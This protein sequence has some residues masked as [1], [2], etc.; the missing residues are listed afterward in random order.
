VSAIAGIVALDAT[1]LDPRIVR[2]FGD[3]VASCA[4]R[5][6]GRSGTEWVGRR[7]ALF[8]RALRP[9]RRI[10]GAPS[11][12]ATQPLKRN[13]CVLVFDGRVDNSEEM[14]AALDVRSPLADEALVLAAYERWGEDCFAKLLGDFALAIWDERRG[15]LVCARD[16]FG[17]RPLQ[18]RTEGG[19]LAFA[20]E[21][22]PLLSL[23]EAMPRP[24]EC[25]AAEYLAFT[26]QSMHET[27]FD[28]VYRLPPAHALVATRGQTR[29]F[30]YWEPRTTRLHYADEADYEAHFNEVFREAVRCRLRADGPV[31]IAL[32]GG[33]D[34]SSVAVVASSLSLSSG[35]E[36]P[37]AV[38]LIYPGLAC[39]ES[40]YI[41][42]VVG[43]AAMKSVRTVSTI[44]QQTYREYA[45]RYLDFPGLPNG[46]TV[47]PMFALARDAGAHV[48]L[49]G[50]AGDDW[51]DGTSDTERWAD[52]VVAGELRSVLGEI[53]LRPSRARSLVRLLAADAGERLVPAMV[54]RAAARLARPPFPWLRRDFV[55]RVGLRARIAPSPRGA[56][57][58]TDAAALA[59]GFSPWRVRAH[60][61]QQ[62]PAAE[63][64]LEL[65]HPFEDRRVAELAL[66]LPPEIRCK[67]DEWKRVLRR[68]MKGLLP[69]LVRTR[70]GKATFNHELDIAL[71]GA[72]GA[73]GSLAI[74][75]LGWVNGEEL[76]RTRRVLLG[77]T[78]AL[79]G[80]WMVPVWNAV[81][82]E[83]WYRAA[84]APTRGVSRVSRD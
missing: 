7:A 15:A 9:T 47:L 1:E 27:L 70:T 29:V 45:E 38:S 73:L 67:G 59:V 65:R 24:N 20:S 55:Q 6:D 41:D 54:S 48:V 83:I 50:I 21:A 43:T 62:R 14:S 64:G 10:P 63:C 42:A 34:S 61:L 58:F 56:R 22:P 79:P 53:G 76:E 49:T 51:L 69:E 31:A 74:A 37:L 4:P 12:A 77:K 40:A 39:D 2:R 17:V 32:S 25:M 52:M 28:G 72:G 33:L 80:W 18:Y 30:R 3:S 60:E 66:R 26:V 84:F 71:R 46:L 78:R 57:S 5:G 36:P 8:H 11:M 81:S 44:P 13:G 19:V 82:L 68:A 35:G 23:T 16:V 75:D